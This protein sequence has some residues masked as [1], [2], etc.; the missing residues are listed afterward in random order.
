MR[1]RADLI[2][3]KE[4]FRTDELAWCVSGALDCEQNPLDAG[5]AGDLPTLGG[6][7]KVGNTAVIKRG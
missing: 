7:D 5:G 1:P 4:S 6:G 3:E 2:R